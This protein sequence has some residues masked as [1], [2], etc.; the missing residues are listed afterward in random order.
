MA[1]DD[2]PLRSRLMEPATILGLL[3]DEERLKVVAALVLGAHTIDDVVRSTGID[4]R[5]AAKALSRLQSSGLVETAGTTYELVT[6][7]FTE[8][9]RLAVAAG[10]PKVRDDYDAPPEDAAVLRT[11]FKDG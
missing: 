11:F 2:T 10:P 9:A 6:D 7:A 4:V 5:R 3:A 8:A 1:Q